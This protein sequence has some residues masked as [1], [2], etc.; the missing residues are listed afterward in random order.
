MANVRKIGIGSIENKKRGVIKY[1][2][3]ERMREKYGRG[4]GW[5]KAVCIRNSEQGR[6]LNEKKMRKKRRK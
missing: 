5:Y 4:R 2:F 6:G 3:R 1:S